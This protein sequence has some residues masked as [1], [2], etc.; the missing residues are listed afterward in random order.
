MRRE[1][2]IEVDFM[3]TVVHPRGVIP[4]AAR[5]VHSGGS[6]G[7]KDVRGRDR[8]LSLYF[9]VQP[10]R[11]LAVC[12]G[13]CGS[14]LPLATARV[15]KA[16]R[17]GAAPALRRR[18]G[19]GSTTRAVAEAHENPSESPP[20]TRKEFRYVPPMVPDDATRGAQAEYPCARRGASA[21]EQQHRRGGRARPGSRRGHRDRSGPHRPRVGIRPRPEDDSPLRGDDDPRCDARARR[22]PERCAAAHAAAKHPP[23]PSG[24][25]GAAGRYRDAGRPAP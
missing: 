23:H 17:F 3:A 7:C 2:L 4:P 6:D 15:K 19:P 11:A 20:E 14:G 8:H 13:Q 9:R 10:H 18:G 12:L 22:Q 25:S 16:R 24:G 21:R 5:E 1:T